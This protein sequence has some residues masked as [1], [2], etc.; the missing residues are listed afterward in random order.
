[1]IRPVLLVEDSEDDSE[2]LIHALKKAGVGNPIFTVQTG[3]KAIAYLKGDK[4]FADRQRFP[5][6]GVVLLDLNLPKINGFEFLKWLST[7]PQLSGL[8]VVVLSG[9][10]EI[11]HV[12]RAYALGARSFLVKPLQ[13]QD[14]FNLVRTY[15]IQCFGCSPPTG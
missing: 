10:N 15:H 6:P 3:E 12:G 2:I 8:F 7:Q 1:M 13:H 9:Y 5:L 4:E 14:I 11:S